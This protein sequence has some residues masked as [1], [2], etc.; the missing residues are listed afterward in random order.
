MSHTSTVSNIVF[1]DI[2][3]LRAAVKELQAGG[4]KCEF[5]VN[6][7]PRA[8]YNN[9]AGMSTV[10]PYVL[11]L[12]E[13]RYDIGFEFDAKLKGYVAKTDLYGNDVARCV[14]NTAPK[15]GDATKY[16]IGKL[17]QMYA[18]HAATRKAN[19]QGYTVQRNTKTD[20]TIQLTVQGFK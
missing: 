6:Q 19:S 14:G 12:S 9:Q 1:S 13:S 20:G 3:A 18:V 11:K 8:Y 2:E 5:V 7:K 15:G 17:S 10:M 16:A 4:L